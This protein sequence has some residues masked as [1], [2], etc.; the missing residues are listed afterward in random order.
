[1]HFT[2][3]TGHV[4]ILKT[5]PRSAQRLKSQKSQAGAGLD[6]V[7]PIDRAAHLNRSQPGLDTV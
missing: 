1:M 2:L 6:A 5:A 7:V 4:S 3:S